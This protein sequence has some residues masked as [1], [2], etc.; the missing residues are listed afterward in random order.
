MMATL[1]SAH[2]AELERLRAQSIAILEIVARI[3]PPFKAM[4][5]EM[6]RIIENATL[7][8]DLRGVREAARDVRSLTH[9]VPSEKRGEILAYVS[10]TG[11]PL[12]SEEANDGASAA[13]ILTAGRI[14]NEREYHL[15]RS[16]LERL[17]ASGAPVEELR[18]VDELLGAFRSAEP[19]A[20]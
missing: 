9:P 10:R 16:H 8:Q 3:E 20:V 6:R 14:R 11:H 13:R 2:L 7:A 5:E 19:D 15:L 18:A 17:E 12:E 4:S 1:K